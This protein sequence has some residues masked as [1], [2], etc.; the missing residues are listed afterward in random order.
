MT[1]MCC[2]AACWAPTKRGG[3]EDVENQV[4]S[5]NHFDSDVPVSETAFAPLVVQV[6]VP[7]FWLIRS[8]KVFSSDT[9]TSYYYFWFFGFVAKLPW[10]RELPDSSP[11][12]EHIKRALE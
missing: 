4:M 9:G 5:V 7:Q 2:Y 8:S 6:D 10:E 11:S 12:F 3:V 1:L